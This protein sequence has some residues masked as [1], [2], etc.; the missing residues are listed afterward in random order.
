MIQRFVCGLGILVV[1][2]VFGACGKSLPV[3]G[4]WEINH[5]YQAPRSS[6]GEGGVACSSRSILTFNNDQKELVNQTL[7][8]ESGVLG[9]TVALAKSPLILKED[10]FEVTV[11]AQDARVS[12]KGCICSAG[13]KKGAYPYTISG[14]KLTIKVGDQELV[15]TKLN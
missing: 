2:A 12:K 4:Q 15:L 8:A 5:S 6:I 11:Y 14:D 9:E 3:E 10:S 1:S 7:C 13:F